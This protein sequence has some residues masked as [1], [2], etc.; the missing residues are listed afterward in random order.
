MSSKPNNKTSSEK[1]DSEKPKEKI[2]P[3]DKIIETKHSVTINDTTINY[4]ATT[5]LIILKEEEEEKAP[6]AKASIFFIAYSKESVDDINK[7]PITFS[8]NGGP[9]S[10]SVWLHLGT[11]GPRRVIAEKNNQPIPPPYQLVNNEYSVLDVTDLVFIDPVSTGYSRAVPGEK[12]KQFHE[13]KKDIETVGEFIRLYTSRYKRWL[14]PKFLIGESYGTTRAAGLVGFLQDKFGMFFNGVMLISSVLNFQASSF[15]P[16]NDIPPLLF[17]PTYTATAWYHKRLADDLSND[18]HKTLREVEEFCQ[19]EYLLA[20]MKG[21]LLSASEREMIINKLVRYTGLS[22]DYIE[23]TNLRINIFRFVK[24]LL[25][26][27]KRTVGRLDSRFR[28][29]DRD[30]TGAEADYDP[31]YAVIQGPFTATFND[32]VRR[33]LD[34]E[35]DLP[36][37]IL[38]T[39]YMKWRYEEHQGKFVNV[40]ETLRDAMSKNQHLKVFVGNGYYDLA[41]PYFA[42]EYT[43]NHL[44]IDPSLRDNISLAYYEAGHMMYVHE[45]SLVKLKDDL[46]KFIKSASIHE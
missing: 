12:P 13:F 35:S 10:S 5:G 2:I 30:A 28:G 18:L 3:K 39:L 20:L 9:G 45:P 24:E 40:A 27:Q 17:L 7:R 6:Q 36:Y 33:E 1:K 23:N 8:F 19:K 16:G 34:F 38:T 44:G 22:K 41:T 25:R 14:S 29:I 15:I 43:F 32:Y 26:D 42:T 4:N 37:E 11:L 31:S 21:D 46:S